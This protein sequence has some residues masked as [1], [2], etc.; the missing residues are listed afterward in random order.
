MMKS[1]ERVLHR[2]SERYLLVRR[3]SDACGEHLDFPD[4]ERARLFLA[5]LGVEPHNHEILLAAEK[6]LGG[7]PA[8]FGGRPDEDEWA[9]LTDALALHR[10]T[11]VRLIDHTVSPCEIVTTGQ[12]TLSE[13]SWG[14]TSSLYPSSLHLYRPD[15]WDPAKLFDLLK[16]RAAVT[17]VAR[18]NHYVRKAKPSA[19]NIDRMMRPYHCLENF[20]GKDAEID[21]QVKWFYLSA[22]PHDPKSH[23]GTSGTIIAKSY[24]PFYNIGGGDAE[25]GDCYLHFYTLAAEGR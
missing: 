7:V 21:E 15:L 11:A 16:A 13:V 2:G 3:G 22:Q 1:E 25:R 5:S 14:E 19:G 10:I 17:D 23:P 18:R 12:L 4:R 6:G 8:G 20:P 9:P 24:G